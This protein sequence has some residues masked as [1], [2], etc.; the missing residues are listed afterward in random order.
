MFA[1]LPILIHVQIHIIA[2][3]L[4][5]KRYFT[6]W[7]ASA[8]PSSRAL[9]NSKVAMVTF[10]A[11]LIPVVTKPIGDVFLTPTPALFHRIEG[12]V[13]FVVKDRLIGA[14]EGIADVLLDRS[15]GRGGEIIPLRW[16]GAA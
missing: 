8:L 15:T 11:R 4:P 5:K 6:L 1:I 13:P 16:I 12:A 10:P 7:R 9:L 14:D 3:D 2:P